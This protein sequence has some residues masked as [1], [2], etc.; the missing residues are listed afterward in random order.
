MIALDMPIEAIIFVYL[1]II[2]SRDETMYNIHRK[3]L[4]KLFEEANSIEIVDR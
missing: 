1:T 4:R 3:I 2:R